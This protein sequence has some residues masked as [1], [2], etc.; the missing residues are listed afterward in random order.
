[1]ASW[2]ADGNISRGSFADDHSKRVMGV[3]VCM[4]LIILQS[5]K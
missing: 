5:G 4:S 2:L 3:S 1:M